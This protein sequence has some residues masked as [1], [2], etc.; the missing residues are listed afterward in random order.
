M[1]EL[2]EAARTVFVIDDE[3][4]FRERLVQ[5]LN[6]R[7]YA[8]TGFAD[9]E[10]ALFAASSAPPDCAIVDLRMPRMMG[11]HVVRRLHTIDS[12]TRIVVL[13]GF[14]SIATA[15]DAVRSGASH[16]LTKPADIKE[17]VH[18]LEHEPRAA[19][20]PPR[21]TVPTLDDVEWEHID[22]VMVACDNNISRA[23]VALGLH[24]RSL[25]RKL[26]RRR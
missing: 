14:G 18:A 13:T 7:D 6:E 16:Y 1:N 23:A 9:G 3:D 24:R 17:I 15:L 5:A 19:R 10:A 12:S 22:R 2:P 26:A 8:A 4:R 11:L 25:Q 20:T 21:P